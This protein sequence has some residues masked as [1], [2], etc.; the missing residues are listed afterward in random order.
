MPI[1][2]R[3]TIIPNIDLLTDTVVNRRREQPRQIG[4]KIVKAAENKYGK[5]KK[6]EGTIIV[7]TKDGKKKIDFKYGW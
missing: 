7:H 1:K 4:R 2:R 5:I 3:Q 6:A